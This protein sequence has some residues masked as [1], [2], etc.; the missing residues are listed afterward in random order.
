MKTTLI[1]G[2]TDGIG[3]ALATR[4]AQAGDRLLLVGR[5]PLETLPPAL[6]TPNT[7]CQLDVS[8][9]QSVAALLSWLH[10]IN[11]HA[12]DQ[13]I[14]NAAVGYVGAV[15]HQPIANIQT[16]IATNLWAPIALSHSLFPL[17]ERA[18]GKFVFVSSVAT[19]VPTP[20]YAVYTAT[21]A[22]LEGFVRSWQ[23]EL[24]ADRSP[25]RAQV[26]R[27]GATSTQMHA[28]SGADVAVLRPERF[29]SATQVAAALERVLDQ[30]RRSATLGLT[31]QLLFHGSTWAGNTV[32]RALRWQR[33]QKTPRLNAA[34]HEQP[35]CVIT[36]AADG[37]GRALAEEAAAAG[38]RVTGLDV[39]RERGAQLERDLTGAGR[40]CRFLYADLAALDGLPAVADALAEQGPIDLLIHNAGISAVG[41]FWI[42]NLARQRAV[43]NINFSAPLVLN[44]LLLNGAQLTPQ[45]TFV[46]LSSLSHFM[47]YPG[48]VVYAATKDGLASY[49]RSLAV[50]A[51]HQHVVTVFPG[52]TRTAHAR[53]YSPDNRREHRRMPPQVLAQHIL[54]AVRSRRRWL[55]PGPFNQA[56]AMLGRWLPTVAEQMMKR[57]LYDKVRAQ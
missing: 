12:I 20:D 15:A 41:P 33:R 1:T 50:A 54:Q 42:S 28:K 49:A 4:R 5:R 2:A 7:Y 45:A 11:I 29:A 40:A 48:A 25:V 36:G 44:A 35:H 37:I 31:N 17:V 55:I 57:T 39:D 53:R 18:Q 16:L 43:L 27:P 56:A 32:D 47:S 30:P 13:V 8:H 19:A 51:P 23:V 6:F 38:Y 52:P 3:L 26:I 46:F 10:E 34:V 24:A 9:E 22:A 21:K 14:H